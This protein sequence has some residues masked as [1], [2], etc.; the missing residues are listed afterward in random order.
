MGKGQ[1]NNTCACDQQILIE[2][3]TEMLVWTKRRNDLSRRLSTVALCP[4]KQWISRILGKQLPSLAFNIY[5][6]SEPNGIALSHKD[7]G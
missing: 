7:V 2:T 5:L 4:S 3:Q 1:N 6:F